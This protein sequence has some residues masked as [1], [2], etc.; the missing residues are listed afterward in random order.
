MPR[1]VTAIGLGWRVHSWWAVVVAVSGTVSSPIV[2]HRERVTLL[3]D[4]AVREPYHAAVRLPLDE[5]K[6][7]IESV[8]EIAAS[9][10]ASTLH[11][12][13][14]SLGSVISVGVVGGDRP[15]RT[16]LPRILT[17]HALLHASERDLYERAVVEG[18]TRAG[19]PVTTIPAKGKGGTVDHASEKLGVALSPVLTALGKALGSPWQQDH[20]DAT[21]AALVALEGLS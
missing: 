12:F 7:L 11:R 14:A 5:A 16:E 9:A 13:V 17:S 3:A 19:L 10:A 4:S 1:E 21:A 20:R 18:A 8:A 2:V 6:A 15:V